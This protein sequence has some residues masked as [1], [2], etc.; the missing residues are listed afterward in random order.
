MTP[1]AADATL[2]IR[3]LGKVISQKSKIRHN[4]QIRFLRKVISQKSKIR[5]NVQ[6]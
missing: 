4:I 2:K 6:N 1:K 3:F 5:R